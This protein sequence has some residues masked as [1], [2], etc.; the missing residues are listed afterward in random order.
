MYKSKFQD[1]MKMQ[2]E[3]AK[4]TWNRR[5]ICQFLIKVQQNVGAKK[6]QLSCSFFTASPFDTWHIDNICY[7]GYN[8][9]TFLAL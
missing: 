5:G 6:D 9:I 8:F 4:G 1:K 2:T 3:E 7:V